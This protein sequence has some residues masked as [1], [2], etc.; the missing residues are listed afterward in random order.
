MAMELEREVCMAI[1]DITKE[2]LLKPVD[3]NEGESMESNMSKITLK[4]Q[5]HVYGEI[6]RKDGEFD[7]KHGVFVRMAGSS[8]TVTW[9]CSNEA[10]ERCHS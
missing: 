4:F 3:Y 2:E 10:Q 9:K 6:L 8:N 7:F 1:S 5:S